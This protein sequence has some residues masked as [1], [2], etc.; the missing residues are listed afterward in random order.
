MATMLSSSGLDG[1]S[2]QGDVESLLGPGFRP[3]LPSQP[4]QHIDLSFADSYSNPS[5]YRNE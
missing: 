1:C 5:F 4:L 2:G 3:Q